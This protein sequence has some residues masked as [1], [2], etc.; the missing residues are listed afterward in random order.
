MLK[1]AKKAKNQRLEGDHHN[2]GD[3]CGY[4]LD[5]SYVLYNILINN[6]YNPKIVCGASDNYS[7]E[8]ISRKGLEN[9]NY[10]K[11]LEGQVHYW[12]QCDNKTIDI[13]SDIKNK[14]GEIFISNNLPESYY[15]LEDSYKYADDIV[16]NM[17]PRCRYCGGK[18]NYCGCNN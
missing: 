18:L 7:S 14:Y 11:D 6:G 4:C 15:I 2:N 13:A 1:Y 12:V 17:P 3:L 5:N 16:S 9:I 8:V 10:V